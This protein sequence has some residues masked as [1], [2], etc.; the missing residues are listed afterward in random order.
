MLD[1]KQS[2][3]PPVKLRIFPNHLLPQNNQMVPLRAEFLV[4]P[5]F[6]PVKHFELVSVD[7][8]CTL[9]ATNTARPTPRIVGATEGKPDRIFSVSA[10]FPC[11]YATK[12]RVVDARGCESILERRIYARPPDHDQLTARFRCPEDES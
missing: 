9:S 11:E 3:V 10:T 8:D 6:A 7:S 4:A 2:P 5:L 1:V 12:Y